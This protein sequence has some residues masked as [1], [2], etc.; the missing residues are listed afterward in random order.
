MKQHEARAFIP[1]LQAWADGAELQYNPN[2]TRNSWET[3]DD[4]VEFSEPP[5]HYRI[6]PRLVTVKHKLGPQDFPPGTAL[7]YASKPNCWHTIEQVTPNGVKAGGRT[8][9][10]EELA[11]EPE[12]IRIVH[13][14]ALATGPCYREVTEEQPAPPT[15]A[16]HQP[17]NPDNVPA[18]KVPEGY[19]FSV[20]GEID[21]SYLVGA[22]FWYIRGQCFQFNR[23]AHTGDGSNMLEQNTLIVPTSKPLPPDEAP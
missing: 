12:A 15:P 6:K 18:D 10:Y 11:N 5:S 8:W 4:A 21:G 9:A 7:G 1:L 2:P 13:G 3:V 14:L 19:R 23:D 20:K 16:E 17:H 22:Q